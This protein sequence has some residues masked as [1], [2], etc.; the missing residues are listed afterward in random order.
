MR[1][2][3][4]GSLV[5]ESITARMENASDPERE[6]IEICAEMLR[7]AA[8]IPGISGANL[9]TMGRLETIPT[10]II[11]SGVRAS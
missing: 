2:N 5:P 3:V 1:D 10:A 11:E 9:T 6:G 8:T 7:E 4:N